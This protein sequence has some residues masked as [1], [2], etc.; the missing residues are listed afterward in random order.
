MKNRIAPVAAAA[1][2]SALFAGNAMAQASGEGPLFLDEANFSSSLT[3]EAVRQQA[4][5]QRPQ[6]DVGLAAAAAKQQAVAA[7]P[8]RAEVRAQT[9]DALQHGEKVKAGEQS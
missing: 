5:A 6:S 7:T 9:R 8:S 2:L 4:I 1:V 3:R